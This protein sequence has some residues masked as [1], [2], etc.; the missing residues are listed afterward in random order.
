[1]TKHECGWR[2]F[3]LE[4]LTKICDG[5]G[6]IRMAT[7]TE[8]ALDA[9]ARRAL[10]FTAPTSPHDHPHGGRR[11]RTWRYVALPKGAT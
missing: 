11:A 1:M 2:W 10:L 4:S 3:S 8:A 9:S 6:V 5:C 7:E